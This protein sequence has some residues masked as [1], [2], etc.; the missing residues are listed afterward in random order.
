MP[1]R[2]SSL[3]GWVV[4]VFAAIGIGLLP[5]S[6]W[7]S[8]SLKPQHVSNHWD[9][10]WSGFDTGLAVLFLVTAFAASRRSPWAGALAA[11]LG[12]LL[13]TDAWFD[14]VLE[15]HADE[16]RNAIVLAVF[17]EIPVAIFCFWIAYR[18]ER[19]LAK[20]L[21]LAAAGERAP[22]R[23]LVG[24]LEIAPDREAAG[25]PRDADASA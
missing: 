12:T 23:D 2:P 17:A 24:V 9:L 11:A 4:V 14:I 8:Q 15:S 21:H 18:T 19:F 20:G 13:L 7:L 3:R 22:E 1:G 6:L 10:A 16:R 5:W 25:E